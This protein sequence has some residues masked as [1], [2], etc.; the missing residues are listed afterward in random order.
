MMSFYSLGV[1][2]MIN[3]K[4]NLDNKAAGKLIFVSAVSLGLYLLN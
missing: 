3:I 1:S 2:N 4:S